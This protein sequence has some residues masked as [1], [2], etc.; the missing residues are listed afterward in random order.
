[1]RE[2]FRIVWGRARLEQLVNI[3]RKAAEFKAQGTFRSNASLSD[4]LGPLRWLKL[5][6]REG[7]LPDLNSD[8]HTEAMRAAASDCGDCVK[9]KNKK[10]KKLSPEGELDRVSSLVS[11]AALNQAVKELS[12]DK[13]A[14]RAPC[15]GG[16]KEDED[17]SSGSNDRGSTD[18]DHVH[19]TEWGEHWRRLSKQQWHMEQQ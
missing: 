2:F 9:K 4:W 14:A 13:R 6:P 17:M 5:D 3:E 7:D 15:S 10:K 1:M 11:A 18:E 16:S 8:V 19:P 12:A